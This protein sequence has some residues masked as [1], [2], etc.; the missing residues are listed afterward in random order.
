MCSYERP[1]NHKND[2]QQRTVRA[3]AHDLHWRGAWPDAEKDSLPELTIGRDMVDGRRLVA[4]T[5]LKTRLGR[6]RENFHIVPFVSALSA[7]ANYS[8]TLTACAR[9]IFAC[10]FLTL[11]YIRGVGKADAEKLAQANS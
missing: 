5:D 7:Q 9:K 6:V 3:E 1:Q 11:C 4:A 2:N 8:T 10:C